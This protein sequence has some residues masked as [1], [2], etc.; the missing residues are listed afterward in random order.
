MTWDC[1][2]KS[3]AS[4][5]CTRFSASLAILALLACVSTHA[6]SPPL[7]KYSGTCYE[8]G[9]GRKKTL[10]TYTYEEERISPIQVR[11]VTR[12]FNADG[13]LNLL[14]EGVLE[15][16]KLIAYSIDR[17]GQGERGAAEVRG[18]RIHFTYTKDG[19]VKKSDVEWTP[20]FVM[21]PS[22][23]A[24]M[25]AH[26]P[27]TLKGEPLVVRMGA[28]EFQDTFG[29]K[30]R[31]HADVQVAGKPA[32]EVHM[33]PSSFFIGIFVGTSRMI[34]SP[35]GERLLE[36]H[37]QALPHLKDGGRYRTVQVEMVLHYPD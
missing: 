31:K 5:P 34:Y 16:D 25:V 29:F 9:S 12:Y 1:L 23:G 28:V 8:E 2:T 37:G 33:R 3:S 24:A 15:N 22:L 26:W 4:S 14:E 36:Y 20:E 11:A 6:N 35:S 7:R 19:Q 17:K 10:F 21:N 27:K 32:V 13:S 18:A 30:F